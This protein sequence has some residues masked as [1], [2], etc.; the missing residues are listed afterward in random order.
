MSFIEVLEMVVNQMS[1]TTRN[2]EN[3]FTQPG[4]VSKPN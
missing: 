1:N 3:L 4:K 2:S